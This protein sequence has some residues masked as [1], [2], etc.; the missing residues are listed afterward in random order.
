MRALIVALVSDRGLQDGALI[1]SATSIANIFAPVAWRIA[2]ST[3]DLSETCCIT[4]T[5]CVVAH[6]RLTSPDMHA[7]VL[8]WTSTL[9]AS[10][11][12]EDVLGTVPRFKPVLHGT[13]LSSAA[14]SF[15]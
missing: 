7:P 5:P 11:S 15:R 3:T 13:Q 14:D 10:A 1:S 4:D 9:Q 8:H 2:E 12:L 6:F